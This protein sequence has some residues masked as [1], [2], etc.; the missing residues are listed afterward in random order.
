MGRVPVP[1]AWQAS[2][3]RIGMGND[4]SRDC[5]DEQAVFEAE[6]IAMTRLSFLESPGGVLSRLADVNV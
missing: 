1:E 4:C 3:T 5:G 6:L 2:P